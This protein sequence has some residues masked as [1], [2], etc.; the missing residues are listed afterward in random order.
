VIFIPF[1]FIQSLRAFIL[2]GKILAMKDDEIYSFWNTFVPTSGDKLRNYLERVTNRGQQYEQKKHP[3]KTLLTRIRR[4][5]ACFTSGYTC[6]LEGITQLT[7]QMTTQISELLPATP[8]NQ[9]QTKITVENKNNL[10]L[11]DV[12][13]EL[14]L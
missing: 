3:E 13:D 10:E 2:L 5:R 9:N 1:N 6:C 14:L 4:I 12:E 11:E 8:Q 7:T